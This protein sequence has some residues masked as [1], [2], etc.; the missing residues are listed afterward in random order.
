[1][2]RCMAMGM[3]ISIDMAMGMVITINIAI[4]MVMVMVITIN[5]AMGLWIWWPSLIKRGGGGL[6][7]LLP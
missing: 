5:M 2:A 4:G 7:N 3:V 6:V 1:M